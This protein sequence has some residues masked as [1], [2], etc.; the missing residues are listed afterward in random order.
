M[1]TQTDVTR[2]EAVLSFR[3]AQFTRVRSFWGISYK[4]NQ[5]FCLRHVG[6]V[7]QFIT[8]FLFVVIQSISCEIQTITINTHVTESFL[9]IW[10]SGFYAWLPCFSLLLNDLSSP[11]FSAQ[12]DQNK[13]FFFF[14]LFVV[15]AKVSWPS[16]LC[17]C[18]ISE[19][20]LE[21]QIKNLMT[22]LQ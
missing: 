15:L 18:T 5:L 17:P 16:R 6:H 2:L 9:C 14:S 12:T 8:Y 7:V 11:F 3:K 22:P 10:L 1:P 20:R 21:T 4:R 19:S 13:A